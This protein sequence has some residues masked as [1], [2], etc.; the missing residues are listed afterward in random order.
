MGKGSIKTKDIK[1]LQNRLNELGYTDNAGNALDVDGSFGPATEQ[2]VNKYK[3]ANGLWN[4]GEYRGVVGITTWESL[5]LPYL[6]KD[7]SFL[8]YSYYPDTQILPPV[9]QKVLTF[10][11][12]FGAGLAAKYSVHGVNVEIG[13]KS[14]YSLSDI[15]KRPTITSEAAVQ[16]QITER[17]SLGAQVYSQ[18]D[19]LTKERVDKGGYAGVVVG[20][21]VY[22]IGAMTDGSDLKLST[23][24][25]LYL[26]GGGEI[27]CS[28]N[29]SE[30]FRRLFG[31]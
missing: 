31:N 5:G 11:L 7:K 2:A 17:L 8:K 10:D 3:D 22:G 24:L 23:S 9:Q 27:E 30:L 29:V 20:N 12:H 18:L 15:T 25:G 1:T 4:F 6:L 16:A 26:G 19:T 14:Y 21:E 13:G 28:L